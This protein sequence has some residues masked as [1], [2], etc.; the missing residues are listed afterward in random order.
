MSDHRIA[1]RDDLA[2]AY[3]SPAAPASVFKEIDHVDENYAALIA[4][5]PFFV[6]A[7]VGPEGLDCSPRGDLPGFVTVRDA[8]TLLIPDRKGN[9]RLDSLKNIL[10]DD[11]IGMLFLIPGCGETLRVN[12]RAEISCDS[13][14]CSQFAMAGKLPASVMIVHVESVYFQCSRAVVRA[15][16]WNPE[17]HVDKRSLPSPGTILRDITARNAAVET[18]DGKAYDEAL[19]ERVK[20]TLY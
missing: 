7:T 8:K 3:P 17:R 14:L 15:E 13:G 9:N 10:F 12:G 5:S 2:R 18:F 19:P 1:S 6:L 16:L 11:R 4:A 20:A